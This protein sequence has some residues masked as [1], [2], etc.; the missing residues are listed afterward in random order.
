MYLKVE[1]GH[2]LAQELNSESGGPG[3]P[4]LKASW[5]WRGKKTVSP[6]CSKLKMDGNIH[7]QP[8]THTPC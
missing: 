1:Q 2:W 8:P 6:T 7:S 3:H 5:P 4:Q